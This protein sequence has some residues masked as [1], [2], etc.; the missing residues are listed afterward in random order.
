M[1][2]LHVNAGQPFFLALVASRVDRS[3]CVCTAYTG[4]RATLGEVT[5][6][7][8]EQMVGADLVVLWGVNAAYS[9]INVMTLVKQARRRGAHVVFVEPYRTAT[10]LQADEHLAVLPRTVLGLPPVISK[11]L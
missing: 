8:S 6:N 9:T 10:A 5:G 1:G 3:I 7:D 2:E 4:W 11:R